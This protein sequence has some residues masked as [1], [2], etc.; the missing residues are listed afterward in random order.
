[1]REVIW[2]SLLII[3]FFLSSDMFFAPGLMA[4][5][6]DCNLM[7]NGERRIPLST[8]PVPVCKA[9]PSGPSISIG[10]SRRILT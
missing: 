10:A 5:T 8:A 6:K 9:Q 7:E 1:M 4:F 2:L 3:A